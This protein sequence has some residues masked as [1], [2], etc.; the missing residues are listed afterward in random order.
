MD[1]ETRSIV[2]KIT[3]RR[4]I[5]VDI[6]ALCE[7]LDQLVGSQVAEVI[8]NHHEIRLGKEDAEFVRKQNPNASP[9]EIVEK[10]CE[11]W[12]FSGIGDVQAKLK[13]VENGPE[14]E[15]SIGAPCLTKTTGSGKSF[16]FSH[17]C[18]TLS[19]ILGG[20]FEVKNVTYDSQKDVMSG[21]IVPHRDSQQ[22]TK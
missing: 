14:L 19:L 13:L 7:H 22:L 11:S 6:E 8:M 18:G 12:R 20:D 9:A 21:R 10:L 4:H 17:W 16:L 2:Q 15:I 5:L 3:G 1:E